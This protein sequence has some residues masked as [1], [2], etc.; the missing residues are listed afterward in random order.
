M[1]LDG[2]AMPWGAADRKLFDVA[3]GLAA[4]LPIDLDINDCMED[5]ITALGGEERKLV[6]VI[7]DE[8]NP[9]VVNFQRDK[10][11]A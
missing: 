3:D 8:L 1:I 7:L 11:Y 6:G 4:V 10:Q 2:P 9:L 5:I